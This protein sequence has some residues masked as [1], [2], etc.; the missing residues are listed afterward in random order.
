MMMKLASTMLLISAGLKLAQ[1]L[2]EQARARA[3]ERLLQRWLPMAG[4]VALVFAG[5]AWFA[6]ARRRAEAGTKSVGARP[7]NSAG[8]PTSSA[9]DLPAPG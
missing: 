2:R 8:R 6:D 3:R 1:T 4:G 7:G 5:G 9:V